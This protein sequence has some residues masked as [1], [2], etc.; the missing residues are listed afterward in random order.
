M[1]KGEI[2]FKLFNLDCVEPLWFGWL[3]QSTWQ[4]A[5][6]NDLCEVRK[7]RSRIS[8]G[9]N[10]KWCADGSEWSE[11]KKQIN[12]I[13]F[14]YENRDVARALNYFKRT[15]PCK[16]IAAQAEEPL[17]YNCSLIS[18]LGSSGSILDPFISQVGHVKM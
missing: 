7:I 2:H 17:R 14:E 4:M 5:L 13:H 15:H 11:H 16:M 18:M 8:L 10:S 9:M 1:K 3:G 6:T 12:E